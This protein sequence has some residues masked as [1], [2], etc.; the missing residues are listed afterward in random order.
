MIKFFKHHYHTRYRGIYRH[1]KKLFVFDLAL[2]ALALTMLV[3]SLVFFFWK[4][5]VTDFVDINFAFN[6]ARIVNGGKITLTV[7]YLNRSKVT[8]EDVILAV[9]LPGGFV[10]DRSLTPESVFP[11]SSAVAVDKLI[12][13]QT[14]SLTIHGRIYGEPDVNEKITAFLT[15][16]QENKKVN[17]QKIGASF[18]RPAGSV[19]TIASD[20]PDN[21]F[22]GKELPVNFSLKNTGD[23]KLENLSLSTENISVSD[24]NNLKNFSLAPGETKT[25]AGSVTM[26]TKD[27]GFFQ[28]RVYVAIDNTPITLTVFQKT[29][30]SIKPEISFGLNS[31]FNKDYV[32]ASDLIPVRVYW[33]NSGQFELKNIKLKISGGQGVI[34]MAATARENKLSLE[35]G[36]LI[37]TQS[38]RTALADG[39]PGSS[40]EFEIK[41]VALPFF[42]TKDTQLELRVSNEAEVAEIPG[43]K[44]FSQSGEMVR[45]PLATQIAWKIRPVYYTKDNDQLGRGPLPPQV[46]E[47]TKYWIFVEMQNGVNAI[48]DNNFNLTL[49]D[50]VEFTGKQSVSI[51]S[52]IQNK[53]S[54]MLWSHN[55]A[56]AHGTIGLYFEV[57]VTPASS[58]IGK[59]ITLIKSAS[60]TA[61]DNVTGKELI[62]SSGSVD[63]TLAN[64]DRGSKAGAVV[65][66]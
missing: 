20:L 22:A 15:Y 41:M 56:P 2:L 36:Q 63:N 33:N 24:I 17:E 65:V 31:R 34:D 61:K 60:Y 25:L 18:F 8:L 64:D 19:L 55:L 21:A 26:P 44:F 43:Q 62:L 29:V 39:R 13:G 38:N 48:T 35:N 7:N 28:L 49:G 4:P 57:A 54:S 9:H 45:L 52:E 47:T 16:R 50:G 53:N 30:Q 51:G 5:G 46:G 58:Q 42:Q 10:V 27:N 66:R 6:E 23:A 32:D 14:G 40:D 11:D 12:P 59:K 1:A 37:I 3:S